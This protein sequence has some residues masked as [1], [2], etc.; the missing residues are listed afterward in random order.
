MKVCGFLASG[1]TST[2]I[3]KPESPG[4]VCLWAPEGGVAP[5]REALC[6]K[7]PQML[8][9]LALSD[10]GSHSEPPGS[11]HAAFGHLSAQEACSVSV[12]WRLVELK[13]C[14]IHWS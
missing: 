14:F 6:P 9:L 7:A 13:S 5:T 12:A 3:I 1:W 4:S 11:W 8:L 2:N 10:I